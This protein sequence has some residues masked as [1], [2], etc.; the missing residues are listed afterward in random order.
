MPL[1]LGSLLH[2][3]YRLRRHLGQGGLGAVYLATDESQ[4]DVPCAIKEQP[5]L[6]PETERLFRREAGLLINLHHPNL[7]R[8]TQHFVQD[9]AQF[10]VMDYVEGE[11]LQQ[12]LKRD[13]PLAEALVLLWAVPLCEAVRYLH[14]LVPPLLHRDIRP[15]NIKLMFHIY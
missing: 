14:S 11:D 8:V 15:A 7:P 3:R 5:V 13:G 2:E 9:G 10:L 4:G 6:S 1:A 12:R